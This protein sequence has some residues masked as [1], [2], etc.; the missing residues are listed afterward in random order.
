[1]TGLGVPKTS[2]QLW[3]NEPQNN[4]SAIATPQTITFQAW[5]VLATG[6]VLAEDG[7]PALLPSGRRSRAIAIRPASDA[8][9]TRAD[10]A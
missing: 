10:T 4:T 7:K 2:D 9:Q 1:M 6:A 3:C 8:I 5:K